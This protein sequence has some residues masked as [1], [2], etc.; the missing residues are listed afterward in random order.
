[1]PAFYSSRHHSRTATLLESQQRS[2]R[3]RSNWRMSCR[4]TSSITCTLCGEYERELTRRDLT[5]MRA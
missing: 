2:S 3:M 5:E 1:M 4:R